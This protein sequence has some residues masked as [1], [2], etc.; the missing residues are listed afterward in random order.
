MARTRVQAVTWQGERAWRK[1]YAEGGH[2]RRIA[3]LR[4]VARR[5]GANALLAPIPLTAERACR[6][7]QSMIN[8]LAALGV[9]VPPLLEVGERELVLGDLGPTLAVACRNEADPDARLALVTLGLRAIGD[10]HACG[11][12]LSQAFAR[13][14][15]IRDGAI[16]FIDLEEDP[17]TT[18]SLDAAQAR[19]LLFYA[20][21]TARFLAAMPGA[22]AALLRGHLQDVRPAVRAEV[23]R[24]ARALAWLV[25]PARLLGGR[26]RDVGEALASLAAASR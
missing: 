25:P 13:N 16:G 3:A 6:T 14:L 7:E 12:Y 20:H 22:H 17:A 15:T 26:S 21:S 1:T 11:G 5:L 24:T 23:A 8:R 4:W 18:M 9:R 2:R 19:D 10:V